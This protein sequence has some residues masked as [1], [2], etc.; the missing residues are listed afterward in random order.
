MLTVLMTRCH[1]WLKKIRRF[2]SIEVH[3][4]KYRK[5]L[6][7]KTRRVKY[8]QDKIINQKTTSVKNNNQDRRR[9]RLSRVLKDDKVPITF[10]S[11]GSE[12]QPEIAS[13]LKVPGGLLQ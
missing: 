8:R 11:R 10:N 7:I 1:G 4:V 2:V 3:N 12:F 9:Y 5:Q 6:K 13:R